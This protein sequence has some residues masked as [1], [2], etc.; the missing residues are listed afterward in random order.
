MEFIYQGIDNRG[1]TISGT[2]DALDRKAAILTLKDKGYYATSIAPHGQVMVSSPGP[3]YKTDSAQSRFALPSGKLSGNITRKDIQTMTAQLHTA[4][5][6]GLPIME[7]LKVIEKQ[8][9]KPNIKQ[10]LLQLQHDVSSGDSLSE[11]MKKHP[12][13]FSPLYLAMIQVGET[14]GILQETTGQLASLL[15]RENQIRSNI[16]S[17][18]TYP[19]FVL[20]VGMISVYILTTF[21]LPR[22]ITS[23]TDNEALLPWP[24][25]V[26]MLVSNVSEHYGW[27]ILIGIILTVVGFRYWISTASGRYTWDRFKLLVPVL[28]QVLR[29]VAVGRFAR[30]LGS[31]THGGITILEALTVVRGTLGNEQLSR[32]IDNVMNAVRGGD[33]LAEP[34]ARSGIFPPLLV[35]IVSVGEQTGKL[36]EMLLDAATTFDEEADSAITR[37]TA[38]LPGILVM[39]LAAVV[40][41]IV[42]GILLPIMSMDLGAG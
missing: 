16:R 1:K 3:A 38:I 14:G 39:L 12:K 6:A 13:F 2:I 36:D 34:L 18:S 15:K 33:P 17:A 9:S 25:R 35:Q 30:T 10:I 42:I 27:A 20:V 28:G 8:I 40:G 41:F 32:E 31:L 24:T 5:Q 26:L 37:F 22:I 21:V 4:L 29:T 11:A 7:C 23:I 19:L